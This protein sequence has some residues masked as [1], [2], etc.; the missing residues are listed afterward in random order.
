MNESDLSRVETDHSDIG[1]PI[2]SELLKE[3]HHSI[4]L[5]VVLKGIRLPSADSLQ[6]DSDETFG[7]EVFLEEISYVLR[8]IV[9]LKDI[10]STEDLPLVELLRGNTA[11]FP[12]HSILSV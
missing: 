4:G 10:L 3:R 5:K 7:G 12:Y 1:D 2:L 6:I 8:S 9:F 11:D